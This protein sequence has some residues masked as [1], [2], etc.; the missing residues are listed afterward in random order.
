M[1]HPSLPSPLSYDDFSTDFFPVLPIPP[2][3]SDAPA[4]SVRKR[5][6]SAPANQVDW[7]RNGRQ[8]DQSDG[9]FG[10]VRPFTLFFFEKDVK[11]KSTHTAIPLSSFAPVWKDKWRC[12]ILFYV[13]PSILLIVHSACTYHW[14]CSTCYIFC[15]GEKEQR[16]V[17]R[18]SNTQRHICI[19]A[20]RPSKSFTAAKNS[21]AGSALLPLLFLWGPHPPPA[22]GKKMSYGAPMQN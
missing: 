1:V 14:S 8:A 10:A 16:A 11:Y 19:R 9:G 4:D 7:I 6:T 21:I 22:A 17:T 13:L 3:L 12:L 18:R 20:Q 2:Q 15:R 5:T